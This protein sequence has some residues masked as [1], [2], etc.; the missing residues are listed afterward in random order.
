M[1]RHELEHLLRASSG[2]TGAKDFVIIGSQSVLGKHPDAPKELRRSMELDI[3]ARD[4]PDLRV[5]I[6]RNL[7]ELSR[8]NETFGYFAD[9]VG[10]D[11]ALLATGW[12]SRLTPVCNENTGGATGWCIDPIDLTIAK[13]AAARPKDIAF[14]RGLLK[15]RFI[16]PVE[17]ER[18]ISTFVDEELRKVLTTRFTVCRRPQEP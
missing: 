13:L 9:G 4:N 18:L 12:E 16:R 7:G 2:I 10:P 6:E 11:T 5:E 14:I 1:N 17:I 3:Y 15:H 8:F